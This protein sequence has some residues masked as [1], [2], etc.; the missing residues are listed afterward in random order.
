[1]THYQLLGIPPTATADQIRSAYWKKAFQFYPDRNKSPNADQ[2]FI[3][4]RL[5]FETLSSPKKREKYDEKIYTHKFP[6]ITKQQ[7]FMTSSFVYA[8]EK[9]R[10]IY[11]DIE[12]LNIS[13]TIR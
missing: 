6:V 5:A 2:Q 7:Q 12:Y 4:V 10:D 9:I 8:D 13:I 3:A 1:M 11:E